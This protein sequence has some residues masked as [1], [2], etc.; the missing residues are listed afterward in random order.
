MS[1]LFG[2]KCQPGCFAH[3]LRW[4]GTGP[5]RPA[6]CRNRLRGFLRR[7]A[8]A[9]GL[10]KRKQIFQPV[11]DDVAHDFEIDACVAVDEQIAESDRLDEARAERTVE[12][13]SLLQDCEQILV[14]RRFTQTLV[15]DDVRRYVDHRLNGKLQGV[16]DE[17]L[18][19]HI[20]GDPLWPRHCSQ[21]A[22]ERF[23]E[24][25]PLGDEIRIRHFGELLG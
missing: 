2:V 8:P 18:F 5:G 13:T 24:R 9:N 22:D 19:A 21:F 7:D 23:N 25:E 14:G 4:T 10:D 6:D 17:S 20:V 12:P 1:A 11:L 15:G 3:L 16:L